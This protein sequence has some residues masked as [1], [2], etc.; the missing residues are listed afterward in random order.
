[1]MFKFFVFW[2]TIL[3]GSS[4]AGV[5]KRQRKAMKK[6]E[7]ERMNGPLRSRI[8]GFIQTHRASSNAVIS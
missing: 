3:T 4:L 8:S 2:L 5:T 6:Y 7:E 1:M